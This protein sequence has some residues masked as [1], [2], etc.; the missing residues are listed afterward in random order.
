MMNCIEV[1]GNAICKDI[2]KIKS[3]GLFVQYWVSLIQS[4]FLF[5]L[6]ILNFKDQYK[7]QLSS[8]MWDYDHGTIPPLNVLF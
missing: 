2:D 3:L 4:L 6:K 1:W 5:Y 7:I 8:L